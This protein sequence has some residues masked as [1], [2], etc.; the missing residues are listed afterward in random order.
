MQTKAENMAPPPEACAPP[1]PLRPFADEAAN[2]LEQDLLI[3]QAMARELPRVELLGL[4][5]GHCKEKA[6]YACA[7]LCERQLAWQRARARER[8]IHSH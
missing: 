4:F 8:S 5:D 3:R 7:R 6:D 2:L 1:D